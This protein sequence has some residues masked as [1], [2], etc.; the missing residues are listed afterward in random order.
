M[1]IIGAIIEAIVAA[2]AGLI[3]A[4]VSLLAGSAEAL[5]FGEALAALAALTLEL[6]VWFVLWLVGLIGALV[7]WRKPV[8]VARPRI[9]R[10]KAKA[11]APNSEPDQ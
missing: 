8:P 6:L 3:E 11:E 1:E 4:L 9:W 5:S 7:H 2:I 10:R